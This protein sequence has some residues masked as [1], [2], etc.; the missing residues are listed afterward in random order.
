MYARKTHVHGLA[1]GSLVTMIRMEIFHIFFESL[2][3]CQAKAKDRKICFKQIIEQT[4]TT[5]SSN[6]YCRV[7]ARDGKKSQVI[8]DK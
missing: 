5:T 1:F 7:E 4:I 6:L 8:Y 2:C 3:L